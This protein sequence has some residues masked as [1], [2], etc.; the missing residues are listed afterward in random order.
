MTYH[1]NTMKEAVQTLCVN[2]MIVGQLV[3]FK[4]VIGIVIFLIFGKRWLSEGVKNVEDA[5][6]RWN[7]C[8]CVS[9]CLAVPEH[10]Y[11]EYDEW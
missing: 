11:K 2:D 5:V 3:N 4:I 6:K 1:M 9:P 7:K 10:L 8:V